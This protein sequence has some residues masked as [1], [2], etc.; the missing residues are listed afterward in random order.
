MQKK[1][2]SLCKLRTPEKNM[3]TAYFTRKLNIPISAFIGD[4]SYIINFLLGEEGSSILKLM[5]SRIF[6]TTK[7]AID[8]HPTIPPLTVSSASRSRV[9]LKNGIFNYIQPLR[10][11][12]QLLSHPSDVLVLQLLGFKKT[13]GELTMNLFLPR[14]SKVVIFTKQHASNKTSLVI[15]PYNLIPVWETAVFSGKKREISNTH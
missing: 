11:R 15:V 5:G 10:I 14:C 1:I 9:I 2:E 7:K 8:C 13:A 6:D 3:R 4:H 12:G